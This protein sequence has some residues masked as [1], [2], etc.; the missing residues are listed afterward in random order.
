MRLFQDEP[1]WTPFSRAEGE[2]DGH[3]SRKEYL[4]AITA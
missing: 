3:E 2:T 1:K 4:S